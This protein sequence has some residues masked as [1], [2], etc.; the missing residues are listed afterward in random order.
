[1]QSASQK[2]GGASQAGEQKV[3]RRAKI[4]AVA[5]REIKFYQK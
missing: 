5:L 2:E 4:G 1:M 3:R